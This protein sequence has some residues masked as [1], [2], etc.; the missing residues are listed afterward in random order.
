MQPVAPSTASVSSYS[1]GAS[2]PPGMPNRQVPQQPPVAP[3][4]PVTAAE[5]SAALED[6]RKAIQPIASELS[7]SLDEDSGRMLLRIIDRETDE[8]IRQIPSEELIRIA[9][10]LDR[11]QGLFL[12]KEA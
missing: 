1:T 4:A 5:I 8:V 11:F 7:F 3:L 6:V 2:S 10:A 12:N 9:K